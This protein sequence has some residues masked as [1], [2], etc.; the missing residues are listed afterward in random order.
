MYVQI[1]GWKAIYQNIASVYLQGM[2]TSNFYFS[3]Y[4]LM[5]L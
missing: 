4:S 2:S 5:Y 3:V 1:K